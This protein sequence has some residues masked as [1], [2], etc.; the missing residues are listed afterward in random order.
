MKTTLIVDDGVSLTVAVDPRRRS[1]ISKRGGLPDPPPPRLTSATS[2]QVLEACLEWPAPSRVTCWIVEWTRRWNV[3]LQTHALLCR[4][5]LMTSSLPVYLC[6][7]P[8]RWATT[9]KD[10]KEGF[11]GFTD[12]SLNYEGISSGLKALTGSQLSLSHG[13]I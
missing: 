5:H 4:H 10:I 13:T 6:H 8:L 12:V 1:L 11:V 7:D 3:E 9:Q 2:L